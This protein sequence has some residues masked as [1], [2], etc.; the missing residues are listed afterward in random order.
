MSLT[1]HNSDFNFLLI[2]WNA[3]TLA[4][5]MSFNFEKGNKFVSI[6]NCISTI[7]TSYLGIFIIALLSLLP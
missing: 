2:S 1:Q 7:I 5:T 4:N 6:T 3:L